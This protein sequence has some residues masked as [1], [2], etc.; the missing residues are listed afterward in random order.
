MAIGVGFLVV[1]RFDLGMVATFF[2]CD[3]GALAL[4]VCLIGNFLSMGGFFA[5]NEQVSLTSAFSAVNTPT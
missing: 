3:Q 2:R 4:L 5:K 1:F